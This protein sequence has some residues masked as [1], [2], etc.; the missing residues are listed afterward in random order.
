MADKF[1]HNGDALAIPVATGTV[2]DVGDL[3][4]V[5]SSGEC[6]VVAAA[7]SKPVGIAET[8]SASGETD[9]VV[10]NIANGSKVFDMLLG[11]ATTLNVG[12]KVK[13][14]S[15]KCV[16]ACTDDENAIGEVAED[17]ATSGTGVR[18]RLYGA[19]TFKTTWV[20]SFLKDSHDTNDRIYFTMP[21]AA[22]LVYAGMGVGV[23][24][25][26]GTSTWDLLDDGTSV[27]T[28]LPTLGYASSPAFNAGT[29]STAGATIAAG[30]QMIFK[31]TAVQVNVEDVSL[32]A[33]F[34]LD[35][36]AI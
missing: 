30:S 21:Y 9:P 6:V 25:A 5:D 4:Y 19:P 18:V 13:Y 29:I 36:F 1:S 7:T 8:A 16:V 27:F 2:V 3:I 14:T 34:E 11:S 20:F 17:L 33:V 35:G 10:V 26:S 31:P 23:A 24:G 32:V 12:Q 28:T 15:D 22:R